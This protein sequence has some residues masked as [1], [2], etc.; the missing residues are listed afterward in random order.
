MS[1]N[2]IQTIFDLSLYKTQQLYSYQ[3][4][5]YI[6]YL[7]T[8][9]KNFYSYIYIY[10]YST[11]WVLIW[12]DSRQKIVSKNIKNIIKHVAYQSLPGQFV[13]EQ[14]LATANKVVIIVI[15]ELLCDKS[16]MIP[17]NHHPLK[18]SPIYSYDWINS[19]LVSWSFHK[20]PFFYLH[21]FTLIRHWMDL[22]LI[23]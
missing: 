11:D 19:F 10:I 23:L 17:W 5:Y 15:K 2:S 4:L 22:G 1:S 8:K 13:Q 6:L 9:K 14:R 21:L 12:I 3:M 18:S 7:W 20:K 16:L